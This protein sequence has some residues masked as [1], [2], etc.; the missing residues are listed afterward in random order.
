MATTIILAIAL[1]PFILAGVAIVLIGLEDT[2]RRNEQADY[3]LRS[4]TYPSKRIKNQHETTQAPSQLE[5]LRG[6]GQL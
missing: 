4:G 2:K 5:L 3:I 6:R 1:S